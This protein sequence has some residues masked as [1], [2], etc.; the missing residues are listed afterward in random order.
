MTGTSPPMEPVSAGFEAFFLFEAVTVG[1]ETGFL[2]D[3][4]LAL[5]AEPGR[6]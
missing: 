1:L 6:F 5:G 2:A 4:G 3:F